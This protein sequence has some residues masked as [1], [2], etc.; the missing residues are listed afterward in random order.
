MGDVTVL[1]KKKRC[2]IKKTIGGK[3]DLVKNIYKHIL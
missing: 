2:S 3:L 1:K